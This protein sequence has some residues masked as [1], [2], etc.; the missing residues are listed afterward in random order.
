MA[1]AGV[2]PFFVRPAD[3]QDI[4]TDRN[5]SDTAGASTTT[6]CDV[7]FGTSATVRYILVK[8]R[9]TGT[10]TPNQVGSPAG[11]AAQGFG[12]NFLSSDF[13]ASSSTPA[14]RR[15]PG[16][17]VVTVTLRHAS[18]DLDFGTDD[19]GALVNFYRRNS[20][21]TFDYLGSAQNITQSESGPIT[22]TVAVTLTSPDVGESDII[23]Q[24]GD[25][26]HMETW[27]HGHGVGGDQTLQFWYDRTNAAGTWKIQFATPGLRYRY[28]RALTVTATVSPTVA[29][30]LTLARTLPLVATATALIATLTQRFRPQTVTATASAAFTRVV[31][32]LRSLSVTAT[33]T[34]LTSRLT[35][36]FRSLTT[37]ATASSV[38]RRATAP[39]AKTVT[40]AVTAIAARALV[41][42]RS[43]IVTATGT[44]SLTRAT[45]PG[46]KT[47]NAT[48][49]A[50]LARG[51]ALARTLV[52]SSTA[53]ALIGAK[54][55]A[56]NAKTVTAIATALV[57]RHTSKALSVTATATSVFTRALVL[58]KSL[59]VTGVA[60]TVAQLSHARGL[61]AS[62]NAT[63]S[64]LRWTIL[65][66]LRVDATAVAS[67]S[68]QRD[69][70]RTFG[71]TATVTALLA[72]SFSVAAKTVTATATATF[73]RAVVRVRMLNVTAAAFVRG[74]VEMSFDVLNRIVGG[75]GTTIRRIFHLFDD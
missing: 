62:V 26:L 48:A 9:T 73:A 68:A 11:I 67:V 2:G 20:G 66:A 57:T 32:F 14:L 34:S 43:L 1:Y 45:T 49:S 37:A 18:T 60:T 15:I 70:A 38:A 24:T 47:V 41:L 13:D 7:R 16:S 17:T 33:A 22:Y 12:V 30:L 65:G 63:T 72:R 75:G 31:T 50:I 58:A 54:L 6:M 59:I 8:P 69:Y 40:G 52:V 29:R 23:F 35:A 56:L 39:N 10:T 36:R 44:A 53:S 4:T 55:I 27:A 25:S 42:A 21:G 28:T 74:K 64:S 46:P 51:L 71:V 5:F 61:V 19:F 3:G